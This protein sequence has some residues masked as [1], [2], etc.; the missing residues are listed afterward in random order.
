MS[1]SFVYWYKLG[2]LCGSKPLSRGR[3]KLKSNTQKE[4][5]KGCK[6]CTEK[7]T[8]GILADAATVGQQNEKYLKLNTFFGAKWALEE[9]WRNLGQIC[10]R[11]LYFVFF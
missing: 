4:K 3:Q 11:Q 1:R 10:A 9:F 7:R 2:V 8:S 6:K 5:V